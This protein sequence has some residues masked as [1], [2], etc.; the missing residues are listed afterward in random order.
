MPLQ[1][2][3]T[4]DYT[5]IPHIFKGW[6]GAFKTASLT[7]RDALVAN[8]HVTFGAKRFCLAQHEREA[9]V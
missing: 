4:N 5:S 6:D 7:Y 1:R 9:D 2:F 8:I 3:T